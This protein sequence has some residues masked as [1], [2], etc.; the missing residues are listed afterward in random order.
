MILVYN[1]IQYAHDVA[2][3]DPKYPGFAY[4]V[5]RLF[6]T[7]GFLIILVFA[8]Y[9]VYLSYHRPEYAGR[10]LKLV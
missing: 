8:I 3:D 4:H 5:T 10:S 2:N 7:M 1:V 9:M 6:D